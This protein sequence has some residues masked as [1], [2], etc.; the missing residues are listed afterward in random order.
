MPITMVPACDP[1]SY[2]KRGTF[3]DLM[4][5]HLEWGTRPNC[6]MHDKSENTPWTISLFA[7][8]VCGDSVERKSA[9]RNITNWQKGR[10][11]DQKQEAQR[12]ANIYWGF[13]GSD[14]HLT[15]WKNDLENALERGR[16]EQ[17]A[18]IARR[19]QEQPL[20][21]EITAPSQE[22]LGTQTHLSESVERHIN[23][24]IRSE[25]QSYSFTPAEAAMIHELRKSEF[26]RDSTVD[27]FSHDSL[28]VLANKLAK[29][30]TPND[31]IEEES[32]IFLLKSEFINQSEFAFDCLLSIE[33][34]SNRAINIVIDFIISD[35]TNWA[36]E[37]L[38]RFFDGR[39]SRAKKENS[40]F[41][42]VQN[43]NA[44]ARLAAFEYLAKNSAIK[45]EKAIEFFRDCS[46]KLRRAALSYCDDINYID[47]TTMSSVVKLL[48]DDSADVRELV[49]SILLKFPNY[50]FLSKL[51]RRARYDLQSMI[52]SRPE[53][54][55]PLINYVADKVRGSGRFLL[56]LL[57]DMAQ[58]TDRRLQNSALAAIP[59]GREAYVEDLAAQLRN[60][61]DTVA[62][63]AAYRLGYPENTSDVARLALDS[64]ASE[65][66]SLEVQIAANLALL[67]IDGKEAS[68]AR[69]D[70]S[71]KIEATFLYPLHQISAC[72][73]SRHGL[74]LQQIA[75]TINFAERF[76]ADSYFKSIHNIG[77]Y[78]KIRGGDIMDI[79]SECCCSFNDEVEIFCAGP[80]AIEC[81]EALK[82]FVEFGMPKIGSIPV[83]GLS[84]PTI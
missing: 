36:Y 84:R 27:Q 55:H 6:S 78:I 59:Q 51:D 57:H 24:A 22:A 81:L 7:D 33:N 53:M 10:L 26:F 17:A 50:D 73:G 29:W 15:R 37:E 44:D 77:E 42:L 9:Q 82:A 32:L 65:H 3:G 67:R 40:A 25:A 23:S 70:H 63:R 61:N 58:S 13:F 75:N 35:H 14:P 52:A 54:W 30:K 1:P 69:F 71:Q 41:T 79:W 74:D 64:A 45:K 47:E 49:I 19:L 8:L 68:R 11:P 21:S 43:S 34:L 20:R 60:Q 62:I 66:P 31:K 76:D 56:P 80:E 28:L 38:T 48:I 5:W 4:R 83:E 16:A 72:V 18:R 39:L 2:P 12:I 46:S